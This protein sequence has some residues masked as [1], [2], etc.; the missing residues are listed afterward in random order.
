MDKHKK[1]SSIIPNKGILYQL[2]KNI[3]L[4]SSKEDANKFFNKNK[5]GGKFLCKIDLSQ[6]SYDI[7]MKE[8]ND[9][10]NEDDN[11][12]FNNI[13]IDNI[14]W[15]ISKYVFENNREKGYKLHKGDI[16][17]LGKYILKVKEIGVEEED[18]RI[19]VIERKNTQK[20]IKNKNIS[21]NNISQIPLN[22]E[23]QENYSTLLNINKNNNININSQSNNNNAI[24]ESENGSYRGNNI[25]IIEHENEESK[26]DENSNSNESNSEQSKENASNNKENNNNL[27]NK[28]N[29]SHSNS[30][31]MNNN[32]LNFASIVNANQE[33]FNNTYEKNN[34][35]IGSIPYNNN[36]YQGNNININNIN[37]DNK[38]MYFINIIKNNSASNESKINSNSFKVN[39]FGI[40]TFNKDSLKNSSLNKSNYQSLKLN[41]TSEENEKEK[42]KEREKRNSKKYLTIDSITKIKITKNSLKELKSTASFNKKKV[43][44]N[45]QKNILKD[46]EQS[47]KPL[48]RICLSEEHE[49]ENPLI[50][51]CNCDGTMKYI[52][53]QCLRLLIQSKIKKAEND[54][55]KVLTFKRLECEIC[56]TVFPEKISIKGSLFSIIDIDK[57]DKDYIVLE[58]MIKE[59]PEEKSIFI[60]HFKNKKEVKVGRATDANIRLNDISVSRAHAKINLLNNSFYLHDTNSKFGTLIKMKSNFKVLYNKPFYVQKGNTFFEFI[61]KKTFWAYFKCYKQKNESYLNYNEFLDENHFSKYLCK[62]EDNILFNEKTKSVSE[63]SSEVVVKYKKKDTNSMKNF[64]LHENKIKKINKLKIFQNN[65]QEKPPQIVFDSFRLQKKIIQ[66]NNNNSQNNIIDKTNE[67]SNVIQ[68][69]KFDLT[70]SKSKDNLNIED[71]ENKNDNSNSLV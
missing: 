11:T 23:Q 7:E 41:D 54:S 30:N 47:S 5:I 24:N 60:V 49:K 14:S 39:S 69:Y 15:I 45:I 55:C 36:S 37:G 70:K 6:D 2:D 10:L 48:C 51:P 57:P 52:H 53:L 4:F 59:I 50:H 31:N 71:Q 16:L 13:D 44:D 35:N 8:D 32:N 66:D 19:V 3:K 20:F 38:N 43:F 63:Y 22:N 68:I 65:N 42:E 33:N 62:K 12:S 46:P 34:N 21:I 29:S 1:L 28:N 18:K 56:K 27:S 67:N 58:G 25:H 40:N 17:K 61:M 9:N 26:N 64:N